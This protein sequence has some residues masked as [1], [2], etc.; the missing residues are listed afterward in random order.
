[1]NCPICEKEISETETRWHADGVEY[2][3]YCYCKNMKDALEEIV[4]ECKL[5]MYPENVRNSVFYTAERALSGKVIN[6]THFPQ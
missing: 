2:H 4:E 6:K 5:L 1:M 3:S